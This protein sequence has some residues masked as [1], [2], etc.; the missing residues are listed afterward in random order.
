MTDLLQ[1]S[2]RPVGSAM[3]LAL[4]LASACRT[5]A[6]ERQPVGDTVG[7]TAATPSGSVPTENAPAVMTLERGP[8]YGRCPVYAVS[9]FADGTVLFEG[10]QHV[11]QMGVHK[12]RV[13]ASEVDALT[14]RFQVDFAGIPDS[15]YV[16][17][18]PGCGQ[19]MTDGPGILLSFRDGTRTRTVRLDTGCTG[20]PRIIRQLAT[21]VD[22]IARTPTWVAGPEG[23]R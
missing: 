22:S 8:C 10:R 21:A 11:Q 12:G 9:L 19:F 6:A 16:Q 7:E 14:R 2:A 5:P 13:S 1:K 17:D 20:A 15:L 23:A 18:A 3:V 4:C